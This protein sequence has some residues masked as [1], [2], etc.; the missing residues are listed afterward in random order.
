M[1]GGFVSFDAQSVVPFGVALQFPTSFCPVIKSEGI[2]M[3][4]SKSITSKKKSEELMKNVG[5]SR[6]WKTVLLLLFMIE[7][8]V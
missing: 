2:T 5:F 7:V 6:R 1:H 4:T 8:L 3:L